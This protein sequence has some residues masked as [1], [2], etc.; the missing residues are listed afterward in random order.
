MNFQTLDL[1]PVITLTREEFIKLCAANPEMKL[2]R[3]AKGELIVI[4]PTGGE[5][6]SFNSELNYELVA[7]NRSLTKNQTI[8]K[9]FDS[10]TGFSL[11]KGSDRSPDAA[12]IS[13]AKW[14]SLTPEQRKGFLP[15]CPEFL[16]ELLSPSDSWKQ[17]QVK[18]EEYMDNGCLLAWLIDPK[19]RRVAIY[20]QGQPV[21]ILDNPQTLSGE[22]V[23]PNFVLD[24]GTMFS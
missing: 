4:S 14:E 15:I 6:G 24:I 1:S 16:I 5:T 19:Y 23:L 12:W 3:T 17:G 13:L 8:G 21:E 20:R 11:P 2:E 18:M 22:S 10:S 7:W 9:T